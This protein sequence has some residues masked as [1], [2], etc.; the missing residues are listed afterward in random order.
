MIRISFPFANANH[1][2]AA[3]MPIHHAQDIRP[4]L[5]GGIQT[6]IIVRIQQDHRQ[7]PP[8]WFHDS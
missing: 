5:N 1:M 6:G 2:C 8:A 7:H 3:E 4:S